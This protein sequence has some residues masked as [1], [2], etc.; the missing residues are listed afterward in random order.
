MELLSLAG[1]GGM[2]DVY[3]ARHPASGKDLALK[4]LSREGGDARRF[5]REAAVL[6][7]F[8]HPGVVRYEGHGVTDD[9]TLFL[10]MEWLRGEGLDAALA[11][12]PLSVEGTLA[13]ARRVAEAL[14]AA[15]LRGV[16]HRDLKPANLFLV[17]G[18]V[19][20]PKLLD[21]GL[22][23]TVAESGL[24]VPG[25]VLGT[26][27]Y[28]AP[29]QIRGEARGRAGRR[30]RARRGDL[31]LPRRAPALRRRAPHR[32]AREGARRG[33]AAP[34]AARPR[35][36]AG[37]RRP[38]P[39]DALQGSRE[40]PARRRG[41]GRGDPGDRRARDGEALRV[42]ERLQALG[43]RARALG[44]HG[45][46]A[47]RG[48]RGALRGAEPLRRHAPRERLRLARRRARRRRGARRRAR[49]AH[50]G[51]VAGDGARGGVAGG[52]G[53]ARRPVRARPRG[54]AAGRARGGGDGPRR[55]G[56]RRAG[57]RGRR[58]RGG[59][60]ARAAGGAARRRA[61]RRRRPR[62]CSTRASRW[63][64]AAHGGGCSARRAR[65]RPCARSSVGRR[66]ASAARR[67]SRRSPPR[68]RLARR[69]RARTRSSSRRRP[70]SASRASCTSSSAPPSRPAATSTCSSRGATPCARGPRSASR[71]RCCAT[72][73]ASSTRTPRR[74]GGA[75]SWPRSRAASGA[76]TS[77][78]SRSSSARSPA[79][80]RRTRRRAP[81]SAPRAPTPR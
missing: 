22:A 36:P 50:A 31:P 74:R 65:S 4:L 66:R 34:V 7:S 49:G 64:T 80:P 21:F 76:R 78:G 33:A 71:R 73:R 35:R 11:R 46:R 38:R 17:D 2:G 12:G 81:R 20:A 15:H 5:A 44:D 48:V 40:A 55:R 13:L 72:R 30:V 54:G 60:A 37:P 26:P 57:R 70:G 14:A 62:R 51:H 27:A 52:A 41:G 18:R 42:G 61:H 79:R 32:R 1:S 47:A 63:R 69:S 29:E 77:G 16:V 39:P 19:D 6:A 8:H 23:R 58:S 59:G 68:W 28:M 67:S 9:G 45:P 10:A 43:L 75:S 24:T 3:R 53:G 56:R 25:T